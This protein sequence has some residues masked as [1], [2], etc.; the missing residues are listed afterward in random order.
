MFSG[1]QDQSGELIRCKK[2]K[3]W[4][5][6]KLKLSK[7]LTRSQ[8]Y[9]MVT[10]N[11]SPGAKTFFD[12]QVRQSKKHPKGHRFTLDEKILALSLYKPSPKAYRL[13]SQICVLPKKKHIK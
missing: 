11:L 3:A 4:L 10:E 8:A 6:Q 7:K 13:L 12:M 5:V 1:N 9:I 2:A